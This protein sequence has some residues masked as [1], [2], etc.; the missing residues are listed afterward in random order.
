MKINILDDGKGFIELIDHM[1]NDLTV[2][3]AARVSFG[4]TKEELD[5]KDIKLIKYLAKHRHWSPF[6]HVQ[7]QF[8]I[9]APEFVWRQAWKHLVGIEWTTDSRVVDCSM[10][11][12]SGRYVEYE[13]DFHYPEK[14]RKQSSNNKQATIDEP[15]D[16]HDIVQAI[17]DRSVKESYRDYQ[18]LLK[19]GVGREQARALLPLA[20]YTQCIMTCSL[21]AAINFIKLR[22]HPAAQKE[23]ALYARGIKELIIKVA[24]VASKELLKENDL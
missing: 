15:V 8:R 16:H 20:F 17:Y 21:Q 22:D 23:I 7:F 6:R 3:N 4:N 10:N 5:E 2:V 9:S 11:E 24:P 13:P 18:A 12:I 14:L 1:G 19:L